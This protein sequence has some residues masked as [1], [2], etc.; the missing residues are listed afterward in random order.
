MAVPG[1]NEYVAFI[2]RYRND[3]VAFVR[4]VC[5]AEPDEWQR[6]LLVAIAAGER[7]ISVRSGHGVGKSTAVAWA[8]L[9]FITT[10]YPCKVVV[11][12]PTAPQL[13]D[14]LF[15]EI[16]RWLRAMPPAVSGLFEEKAERIELKAAPSES[17]ISARTSRAEQPEALQGVHADHVM[18]VADEA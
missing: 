1:N 13:F 15:A 12:A 6:E 5:G 7:R 8:V 17:F 10:R 9:W 18:L 11:T 3:P 2:R 14:A 4:E 16:K